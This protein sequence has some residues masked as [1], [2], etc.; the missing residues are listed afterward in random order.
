MLSNRNS[1]AAH[2]AIYVNICYIVYAYN[3]WNDNSKRFTP[4]SQKLLR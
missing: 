3:V 1:K 2:N 4:P